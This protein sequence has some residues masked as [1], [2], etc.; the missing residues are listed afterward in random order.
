MRVAFL[1]NE[2]AE[3]PA[4]IA[5]DEVPA[6]SPVVAALE[7]LGHTVAPIACTLDLDA[8]RCAI[9]RAEPDVAF[10]RV[11]SLGGSD[12]M[13]AAAA[14]L[15]DALGIPYTGNST[16]AL[17]ATASKL[18]VKQ[19]L[20]SVG[21]P[22]PEWIDGDCGL[23]SLFANPQ[24]LV[25][26]GC[27]NPQFILKS[28][29]EHASFEVDDASVVEP[30]DPDEVEELVRRRAEESGRP[31]F[32]E[33]YIEGR[34]FNLSLLADA[35][36]VLPPA[37]IDFSAFPRG[38]PRIVGYGA[39]WDGQSFEYHNTPRRFDF[40]AGD[41]PLLDRLSNSAIKCWRLFELRGYARVDFRCDEAGQPWVLE[42]NANP[43][44]SPGSGFAAALDRAG[45]GYDGG[46]QRIL[47]AAFG[48][49]ARPA[50]IVA[51]RASASR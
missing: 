5:E 13:M 1:Y 44:L 50:K 42:V 17:V 49:G 51:A 39:K 16:A 43:C 11:E 22:T 34:E 19:R 29:Y 37:E 32:A 12:A 7:R 46:I 9:D 8:V 24:S 28:V 20:A 40:P 6:R 25:P 35:P 30:A 10:N 38:K 4:G 15:L 36:Q 23:P 31:F 27:R 2:A 3:D 21:L 18:R 41:A 48:H 45:I 26:S 33:R 14:L 47:E